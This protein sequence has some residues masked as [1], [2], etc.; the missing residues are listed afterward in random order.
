MQ[1]GAEA[2]FESFLLIHRQKRETVSLVWAFETSE[3]TPVIHFPLKG[4]TSKSNSFK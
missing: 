1:A 3:S 2:V 4:H